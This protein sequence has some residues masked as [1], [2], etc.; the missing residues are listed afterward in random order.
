MNW[1]SI[2]LTVVVDIGIYQSASALDSLQNYQD[3]ISSNIAASSVPGFK[4]TEVSYEAVEA[5]LYPKVTDSA[6][7][8]EM[9]AQFPAL[10]G[11]LNFSQGE[12]IQTNNPSDV[13]L[14]G[15][16][17]FVLNTN[18]GDPIYTRNGKFIVN[19]DGVL[20]NNSGHEVQGTNGVIQTIP[21]EGELIIDN[22]GAVFQG[23]TPLGNLEI[24]NFENPG[25]NLRKIDGGFVTKG[26][27]A[28]I[29]PVEEGQIQ[30]L[31]GFVENSNVQPIKEM[32]NM[33][34]VS[35]AYEVNSK[36]IQAMDGLMNKAINTL[37]ATR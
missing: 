25:K 19:S 23:Q 9:P 34:Q 30:V 33:I 1:H 36:V 12:V 20:V 26:D 18:E 22:K 10:R 7:N 4:Q 37:G 17:F 3:I 14:R 24:V 2:C 29:N 8:N 27:D 31:Q 11:Q 15:D 6:L 13:A 32:V 28:N 16:G 5:G 21:G 35:R